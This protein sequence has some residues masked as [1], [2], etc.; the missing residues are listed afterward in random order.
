MFDNTVCSVSAIFSVANGVAVPDEL[1]ALLERIRDYR[2][3]PEEKEC[4]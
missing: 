3:T 1:K 2:M 4:Q